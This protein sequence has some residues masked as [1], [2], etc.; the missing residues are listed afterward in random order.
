M[1]ESF[2]FNDIKDL[3]FNGI[4]PKFYFCTKKDNENEILGLIS[5]SYSFNEDGKLVLN[6][7]H[8]SALANDSEN[9]EDYIQNEILYNLF[10]TIK[11]KPN[12]IIQIKLKF[13][14]SS[15]KTEEKL[16]NLFKNN[17]FKIDDD[18]IEYEDEEIQLKKLYLE[19][20]NSDKINGGQISMDFKSIL[21]LSKEKTEIIENLIFDKYLN[22]FNIS[23][24]FNYLKNDD[25][26]I[27]EDEIDNKI[28]KDNYDEIKDKFYQNEISIENNQKNVDIESEI[29]DNNKDLDYSILNSKLKLNLQSSISEKIN[30]YIYNVIC[31]KNAIKKDNIIVI[32][33]NS[34]KMF[35]VIS[36][37]INDNK[38]NIYDDLYNDIKE[39]DFEEIYNN[40]LV[41]IWIP[42]FDISSHLFS[43]KLT[44]FEN[45]KITDKNQNENYVERYDEIFNVDFK[46]DDINKNIKFE[47]DEND[48]FIEDNFTFAIVNINLLKDYDIPAIM[49]LLVTKDNWKMK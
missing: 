29:N 35:V 22:T 33:T 49:R 4:N 44:G 8:L 5:T 23:L 30:G 7:N 25:Y 21:S 10:A 14:K 31:T 27:N 46:N 20:N 17:N 1:M 19:T 43:N 45:I 15:G 13:N 24:L 47:K 3:I 2:E 11:N 48:I 6:I 18:N 41:K 26:N 34:P 39:I 12:E 9:S 28:L 37:K 42:S 36:T 32:P 40:E 16:D 38:N